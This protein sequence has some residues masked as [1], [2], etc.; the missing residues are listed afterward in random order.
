MELTGQIETRTGETNMKKSLLAI[1]I[2]AATLPFTFAAQSTAP[3]GQ[4]TQPDQSKS[5][6][7]KTKKAKKNK[8]KSTDQKGST[9]T[10][11]PPQK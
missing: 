7:T 8:K 5:S 9:S 6:T 3:S 4:T 10:T 2:S 1:V 11:P